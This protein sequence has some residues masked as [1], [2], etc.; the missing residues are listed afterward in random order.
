MHSE[1]LP[2]HAAKTTNPWAIKTNQFGIHNFKYVMDMANVIL[3]KRWSCIT[4]FRLFWTSV[5]VML[6][7]HFFKSSLHNLGAVWR[8]TVDSFREQHEGSWFTI[9][10]PFKIGLLVHECPVCLFTLQFERR[11]THFFFRN[12]NETFWFL[13]THWVYIPCLSGRGRELVVPRTDEYDQKSPFEDKDF[14]ED[15][16]LSGKIPIFNEAPQERPA[17]GKLYLFRLSTKSTHEILAL[18]IRPFT[19]K[20]F[21]QL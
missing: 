18:K 9:A 7:D 5:V 11:I 12:G 20:N 4:K 2:Y 15:A 1:Q 10:F 13:W 6:V 14:D 21:N 19:R 3:T 17:K 16:F 8:S